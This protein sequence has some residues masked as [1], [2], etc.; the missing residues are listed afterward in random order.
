MRAPTRR[1]V[2][3]A[4]GVAPL[5]AAIAC[6]SESDGGDDDS[7]G[8][9]DAATG[10]DAVRPD[11]DPG[12]WATGGTDAM[13]DQDSYPDPF[14]DGPGSTCALTCAAT[15]GPCYADTLD[16]KDISEGEDGLPVRMAFLV[17]DDDCQ[18]VPGA[19]V[20]VWHTSAN[21]F[22]SGSDAVAQCTLGNADAEAKRF[23]RGVQTTDASGRV[24][25]DTCFPGWY[26]GRTIHIHFQVRVGGTEYLTSQ[27]YWPDDV[28]DDIIDTQPIYSA[29]GTRDRTNATDGIYSGPAYEFAWQRM[30]DGAMLAWKTLVVRASTQDPLC[31]A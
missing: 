14:A 19:I 24:D 13:T 12:G 9:P 21:G 17:V 6:K 30:T 2:L 27:L 22:Y 3:Q 23:F 31:N 25:F 15:L 20:D 29:R 7:S 16:R 1:K 18:P 8:G 26:S 5:A 4:I 10:P 11:A 28:C